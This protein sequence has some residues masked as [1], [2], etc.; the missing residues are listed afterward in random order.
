MADMGFNE[1]FAV[2]QALGHEDAATAMNA[3][4]LRNERILTLVL[5]LGQ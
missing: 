1:E 3:A 2:I 5:R 4:V